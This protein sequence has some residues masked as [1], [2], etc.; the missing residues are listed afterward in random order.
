MSTQVE[1]LHKKAR[2]AI[3][4]AERAA[5]SDLREA[6]ECLAKANELGASQEQS[7][8]AVGK[9]KAWVSLV[10]RWR[11]ANYS[12]PSP[13]HPPA[14][15]KPSLS[16]KRAAKGARRLVTAEA[17]QAMQVRAHAAEVIWRRKQIDALSGSRDE[18]ETFYRAWHAKAS[19]R[20][21]EW[22]AVM[23]LEMNA[24]MGR[25]AA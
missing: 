3:E 6:A 7:G 18:F 4:S 2:Y 12:Y 14:K 22:A 15:P 9:S 5:R 8:A 10:L 24:E 13:F 25:N 17:A 21:R 19:P 11:K 16:D 1:E 23:V 20:D